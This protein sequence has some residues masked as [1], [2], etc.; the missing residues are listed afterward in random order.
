MDIALIVEQ[1]PV[2]ALAVRATRNVFRY[3]QNYYIEEIVPAPAPAGPATCLIL[4]FTDEIDAFQCAYFLFFLMICFFC[5]TPYAFL[6]CFRLLISTIRVILLLN[7]LV[8]W[9][10]IPHYANTSEFCNDLTLTLYNYSFVNLLD[11]AKFVFVRSITCVLD[12]AVVTAVMYV[13]STVSI[14]AVIFYPS[15]YPS[16]STAE[17]TNPAP[18]FLLRFMFWVPTPV[19]PPPSPAICCAQLWHGSRGHGRSSL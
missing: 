10:L 3:K 19:L 18:S 12:A 15:L 1:I 13:M 16:I 2:R 14:F 11:V 6:G 4:Y 9:Q 7:V 17:I 5:L 8:I